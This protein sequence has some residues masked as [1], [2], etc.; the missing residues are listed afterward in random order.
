MGYLSFDVSTYLSVRYCDV[1][2]SCSCG[3]FM[4][5]CRWGILMCFLM[6]LLLL[7]LLISCYK[8]W[9]GLVGF[10]VDFFCYCFGFC[11]L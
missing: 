5:V 8:G 7:C 10:L 6:C 3:F 2:L 11:F 4:D 9:V 1:C